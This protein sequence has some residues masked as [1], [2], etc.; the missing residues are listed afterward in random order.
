MQV[1]R[2]AWSSARERAPEGLPS[3]RLLPALS[4][5]CIVSVEFHDSL[6]ATSQFVQTLV[7]GALARSRSTL[8]ALHSLQLIGEAGTHKPDLEGFTALRELTLC[9]WRDT[10]G[11]LLAAHLPS[12]LEELRV[13]EHTRLRERTPALPLPALSAFDRLHSLRR[14]TFVG[15]RLC[16]LFGCDNDGQLTPVLLPRSLEV[17]TVLPAQCV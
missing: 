11:T 8:T 1:R 10:S 16:Q 14:I 4:S 7:R 5:G 15:H 6:M 17:C 3:Q 13:E 2:C 12:S 9:H